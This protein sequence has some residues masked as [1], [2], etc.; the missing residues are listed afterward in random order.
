MELTKMK[1]T[2]NHKLNIVIFT[3]FV[4]IFLYFTFWY[5]LDKRMRDHYL[6]IHYSGIVTDKFIDKSNHSYRII[7][8]EK[9]VR[10]SLPPTEYNLFNVIEIGDS[11]F[12]EKESLIG[13][14]MKNDSSTILIPYERSI[15][16]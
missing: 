14:I 6:S 4:I 1:L 8:L 7:I 3:S 9:D 16:K 10:V 12:K 2:S 15:P 13:K 11:M 5:P